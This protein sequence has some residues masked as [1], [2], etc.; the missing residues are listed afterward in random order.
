MLHWLDGMS[1]AMKR[2]VSFEMLFNCG[3]TASQNRAYSDLID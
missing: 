2:A 1:T 3:T